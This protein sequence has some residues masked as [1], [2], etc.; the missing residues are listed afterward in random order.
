MEVVTVDWKS[1]WRNARNVGLWYHYTD[2]RSR[3]LLY[4]NQKR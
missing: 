3:P 2:N 4:A 1:P